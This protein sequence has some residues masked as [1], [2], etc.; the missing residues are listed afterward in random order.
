[1][2]VTI[3]TL[4]KDL[5]GI[6]SNLKNPKLQFYLFSHMFSDQRVLR[7]DFRESRHLD[8]RGAAGLKDEKVLIYQKEKI[9]ENIL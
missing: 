1:M 8:S 5:N 4:K 2:K 9:V 7:L 3:N 6:L